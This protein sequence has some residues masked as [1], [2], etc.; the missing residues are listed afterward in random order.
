MKT[1]CRHPPQ[2]DTNAGAQRCPSATDFHHIAAQLRQSG[3]R[4]RDEQPHSQFCGQ[5][6][7][8]S[9]GPC[10]I[11]L[12]APAARPTQ[13]LST[14]P[15]RSSQPRPV[16]HHGQPSRNRSRLRP[17]RKLQLRTDKPGCSWASNSGSAD[18]VNL[19]GPAWRR[20]HDQPAQ[21]APPAALSTIDR[22]T[23]YERR[24]GASE[25]RF[26][27]RASR[28]MLKAIEEAKSMK[29]R[30]HLG[31]DHGERRQNQ[32]HRHVE[33]GSPSLSASA[34]KVAASF[35]LGGMPFEEVIDGTSR[36]ARSPWCAPVLQRG[37]AFLPLAGRV[38]TA[39][40]SSR[41]CRTPSR[42]SGQVAR[43]RSRVG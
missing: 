42:V 23:R 43:W 11:P 32:P 37:S 20:T 36:V 28:S 4:Q 7:T 34:C 25:P 1:T 19:P 33:S 15:T 24:G 9:R 27:A 3:T 16:A 39:R 40:C 41:R 8:G 35:R 10:G 5:P 12:K 26:A 6:S 22:K 18:E 29:P 13:R 2:I 17:N 30:R 21:A 31:H 14:P 38:S